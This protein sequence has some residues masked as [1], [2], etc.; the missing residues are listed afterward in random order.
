[1]LAHVLFAISFLCGLAALL[2]VV[3][4]RG[5]RMRGYR[6]KRSRWPFPVR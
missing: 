6:I 1:M 5:A 3:F 2:C 4:G